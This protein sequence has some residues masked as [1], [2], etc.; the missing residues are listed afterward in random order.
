MGQL[1]ANKVEVLC[2]KLIDSTLAIKGFKVLHH[3]GVTAS[4]TSCRWHVL[5]VFKHLYKTLDVFI[6]PH[7]FRSFD[8]CQNFRRNL[9]VFDL[10]NLPGGVV[11]LVE[12][13]RQ[14]FVVFL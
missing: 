12:H 11:L 9:G 6:V 1:V 5:P 10:F 8:L 4:E 2:F 14:W 7:V 13:Q 3:L